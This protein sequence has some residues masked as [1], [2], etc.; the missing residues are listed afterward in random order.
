MSDLQIPAL[1]LDEIHAW[2]VSSAGGEDTVAALVA[3]LSPHER[4]RAARMRHAEARR[5]FV[6]GRARVRQI[7]GAYVGQPPDELDVVT[8]VDDRPV[9]SGAPAWFDFS[10][11]RCE[12][13]HVCAV[14]RGRR[15]G[16]D[17]MA[18]P[19]VPGGSREEGRAGD[20]DLFSPDERRW[21]AA[22]PTH[23][24]LGVRAELLTK[25]EALSKA[26]GG[27]LVPLSALQVPW[28]GEGR[29]TVPASHRSGTWLVRSFAAAE[30]IAVAVAAEGE[31]RL[32][33]LRDTHGTRAVRPHSGAVE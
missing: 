8:R 13:L 4:H 30:G 24:V 3:C 25:K 2:M 20:E 16:I 32:T 12:D 29:V 5:A 14:A 15:V 18:F 9:L 10:F 22:Q 6:I 19:P 11:S 26:I 17:V 21:L 7:L 23:S 27:G 33:P 1:A 28:E 31:W